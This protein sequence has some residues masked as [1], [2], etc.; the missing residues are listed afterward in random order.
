MILRKTGLGF[1]LLAFLLLPSLMLDPVLAEPE[2]P[3]KIRETFDIFRSGDKIGTN[4]VEIERQADKTFVK[5]TTDIHVKVLYIEAYHYQ[6]TCVETWKH[7]ELTGFHSETDDNGQKHK[8]L[9]VIG[10]DKVALNIDGKLSEGPKT[11]VPA[12]LWSKD[13]IKQSELFDPGNG[14]RFSIKV[15]D[16]GEEPVKMGGINLRGHHYKISDKTGEFERDLWF[17]GDRLIRMK[18][19]GRDHSE[20]ISDLR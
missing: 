19:I 3:V 12:S 9:A 18:L 7:N 11:L 20:I 14:Q 6:H 15:K 17:D 8:I 13:V 5:I 1:C 2:T 16:L 4:S 10:P